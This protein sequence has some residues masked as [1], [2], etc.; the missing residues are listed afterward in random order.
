MATRPEGITCVDWEPVPDGGKRC[1]YFL[2]GGPCALP[3][4]LMCEEWEKV[5]DPAVVALRRAEQLKG[6][7][8]PP[9]CAVP[10]PS[11]PSAASL[12]GMPPPAGSAQEPNVGPDGAL[13]LT[14]AE[15]KPSKAA[16][17]AHKAFVAAFPQA[18]GVVLDFEPLPP[19]KEIPHENIEALER[20]G[21]E[22]SFEVEP[23]VCRDPIVL[24]PRRTG[25]PRRFELT[26]REAAT[27]RLIVDAFPGARLVKLAP[28]AIDTTSDEALAAMGEGELEEATG[29]R[30]PAEQKTTEATATTEAP[31]ALPKGGDAPD[32]FEV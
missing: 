29:E 16:Q 32:P 4:R 19:A 28:A 18:A 25:Q 11:A 2:K 15:A 20:A 14:V 3:S 10:P 30:K 9:A 24:V 22:F 13:R 31:K 26:F 7:E 23:S 5:N 6:K 21:S 8:G 12:L 27:L 17:R 1:R